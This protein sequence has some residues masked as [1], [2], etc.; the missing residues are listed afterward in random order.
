M[1]PELMYTDKEIGVVAEL[2]RKFWGIQYED[3]QCRSEGYGDIKHAMIADP[4]YCK[5]PTDMT[6]KGS[7]YERELIKA[8][9][10]TVI[11]TISWELMEE[12]K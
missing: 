1:I 3:G 9:L 12:G 6:Y 2:D 8:K 11:K 10:R 4:K 7:P 5:K